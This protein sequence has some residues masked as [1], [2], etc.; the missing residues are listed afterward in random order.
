MLV[1]DELGS[2]RKWSWCIL[3]YYPAFTWRDSR[4][5]DRGSKLGSPEYEAGVPTVQLS[6]SGASEVLIVFHV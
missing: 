2:R 5:F 3:K 6:R 1:N 4:S